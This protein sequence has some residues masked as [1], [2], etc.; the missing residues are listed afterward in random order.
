MEGPL[1]GGTLVTITGTGF[2]GATAVY[3]GTSPA[4]DV[5]VLS[6]TTIT[7]GSPAGAARSQS[8]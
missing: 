3:F 8:V 5:T 6:D 1:A 2:A 7:A 4:T